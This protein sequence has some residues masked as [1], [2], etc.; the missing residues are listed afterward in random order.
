MLRRG[1][2]SRASGRNS[3]PITNAVIRAMIAGVGCRKSGPA[4]GFQLASASP[5]PDSLR[6]DESSGS[7]WRRCR[8]PLGIG[9]FFA[10]YGRTGKGRLGKYSA[11][12]G[13]ALLQG[14]PHPGPNLVLA[15]GI[16]SRRAHRCTIGLP[17]LRCHQVS[18][19]HGRGP[20]RG[21]SQLRPCSSLLGRN[22]TRQRRQGDSHGQN[23]AGQFPKHHYRLP[24][25]WLPG[26]H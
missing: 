9:S 1:L 8:M 17:F 4:P 26:Y 2:T 14:F 20:S 10:F 19:S 21:S 12:R 13:R 6:R 3:R 24:I 16:V 11:L 22:L 15:G 7:P 23:C 25:S 18:R 5:R